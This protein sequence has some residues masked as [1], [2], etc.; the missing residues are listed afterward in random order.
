LNDLELGTIRDFSVFF[1]NFWLRRT[2]QEKIE[3]KWLEMNLDNLRRA[4]KFS[5]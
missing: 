5:A 1:C 2:F 4:M 3:P